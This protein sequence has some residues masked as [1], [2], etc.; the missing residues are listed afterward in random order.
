MWTSQLGTELTND[1]VDNITAF[2]ESLTGEQPK[3]TYPIM[4][5]SGGGTPRPEP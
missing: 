4:P 2:L 3:V 5:P 1:E